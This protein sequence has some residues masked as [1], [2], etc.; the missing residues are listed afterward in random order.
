MLAT[1]NKHWEWPLAYSTV[2]Q[3][4]GQYKSYNIAIYFGYLATLKQEFSIWL[5]F[6]ITQGAFKKIPV[7]QLHHEQ[8]K[9]YCLRV[10]PSIKVLKK[11]PGNCNMMPLHWRVKN[12]YLC[13]IATFYRI[14]QNFITALF[15]IFAN[16]LNVWLKRKFQKDREYFNA[17]RIIAWFYR[18]PKRIS[19]PTGFLRPQWKNHCFRV[20]SGVWQWTQLCVNECEYMCRG[21]CE[22]GCVYVNV[23]VY[24]TNSKGSDF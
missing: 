9:S 5:H 22:Q 17:I 14:K 13:K 7:S 3:Q 15:Y 23:C 18:I 12:I 11:S 20:T 16:P 19:R 21:L 10:K 2:F 1:Q 6:K 8:I 24:I 4:T